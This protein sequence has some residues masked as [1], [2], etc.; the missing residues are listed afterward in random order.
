MGER[1]GRAAPVALT[2]YP[3]AERHVA[4]LEAGGVQV[5]VASRDDEATLVREVAGV[6]ALITRGPARI[7]AAVLD[8][9]GGLRVVSTIGSGVDGIDVARAAA[10]GIA[11]TS[12]TGVGKD[13]VAEWVIGALLALHRRLLPAHAALTGGNLEWST[14]LAV[15][16]SRQ[17]HGS[18][19]G[20]IGMGQIGRR[21]AQLS[22]AFDMRVWGYG[23]ANPYIP[24][25]VRMTSDLA[26]LLVASDAVTVNLPLTARTRHLIGADQLAMMRP[27]SVLIDASRGGVVDQRALADAL[28]EGRLAGAAIDVFAAEPP[29]SEQLQRLARTSRVILSPH[30]A[31]ATTEALDRLTANAV[32]CVLTVLAGGSP[33]TLVNPSAS[34]E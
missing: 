12:G 26:E 29:T 10:A 13:A 2:V 23:S 20:I 27:H 17:V 11:V 18:T 22:H 33:P 32:E 28:T 25:Y 21:I 16:A 7:T 9:A 8:A 4:R 6:S 19:V 31:G 3:M 1:G 24:G 15:H 5:R 30:V 14:R 34:P